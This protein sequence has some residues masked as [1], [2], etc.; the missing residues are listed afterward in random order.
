MSIIY[1]IEQI[2]VNKRFFLHTENIHD[3]TLQVR[4]TILLRPGITEI[5]PPKHPNKAWR[6][7]SPGGMGGGHWPRARGGVKFENFSNAPPL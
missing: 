5:L 7:E 6:V 2:Y 4:N 1:L 3:C